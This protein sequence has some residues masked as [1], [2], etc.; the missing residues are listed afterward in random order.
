MRK[1]RWLL[2]GLLLASIV[3]VVLVV[4]ALL[5]PRPGVTKENFDR[6][7]NGMTRAEVAEILGDEPGR[8]QDHLALWESDDA[9]DLVLI[10]FDD[11]DR[12][13]VKNWL[14]IPD[15]RTPFE[16]LLDR[17]PWRSRPREVEIE[18]L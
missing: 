16:K 1:T 17:L 9:G 8:R 15:E 5:P 10:G 18:V 7:Q 14:G 6:I 4:L 13:H 3:G 2:L 12:V 11:A